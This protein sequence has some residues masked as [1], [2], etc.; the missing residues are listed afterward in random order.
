MV[1]TGTAGTAAGSG[2]QRFDGS[3]ETTVFVFHGGQETV[4]AARLKR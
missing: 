3:D 4:R 1:V 2:K